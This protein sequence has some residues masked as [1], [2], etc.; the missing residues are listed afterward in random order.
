MTDVTFAKIKN[1]YEKLHNVSLG[2]TDIEIEAKTLTVEV[3]K[4]GLRLEGDL[5]AYGKKIT[6]KLLLSTE[7][8]SL[9]ATT[10]KWEVD[11]EK[12]LTVENAEISFFVGCVGKG[13]GDTST[14]SKAVKKSVGW[15]G[16]F[17]VKGTFTYRSTLKIS[18]SLQIVHRAGGWGYIVV[19]QAESDLSLSD[20]V[21]YCPKHGNL[22]FSMK[23]VWLVA[24]NIDVDPTMLPPDAQN[25]PVK[26]G[27]P[28]L[29]A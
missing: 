6:A 17:S 13:T 24:S 26:K 10:P 19:G 2:D 8:V 11:K 4:E 15:S 16:G 14:A 21:D 3:S 25:F 23:K 27:R 20:L 7:G 22:D 18:V 28:L 1:L 9:S 29:R 12:V 5:T